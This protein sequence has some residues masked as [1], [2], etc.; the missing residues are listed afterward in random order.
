MQYQRFS[1]IGTYR[2]YLQ[3]KHPLEEQQVFNFDFSLHSWQVLLYRNPF[4]PVCVP[5]ADV[6]FQPEQRSRTLFDC[7]PTERDRWIPSSF[8]FAFPSLESI[9]WFDHPVLPSPQKMGAL[10][11]FRISRSVVTRYSFH[12]FSSSWI[13]VDTAPHH[14]MGDCI[15]TDYR[16]DVLF[17]MV[18]RQVA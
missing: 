2:C 6:R 4:P 3:L 7:G 9:E 12:Q 13:V 5:T 15:I 10:P 17:L 1:T 11:I 8:L 18:S 16:R 14:S